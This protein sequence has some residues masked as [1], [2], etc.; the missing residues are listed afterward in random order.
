MD[1]KVYRGSWVRGGYKNRLKYGDI[2]LLNDQDRMCC[3]G[4]IL[5]QAGVDAEILFGIGYPE[6]ID[7]SVID[8]PISLGLAIGPGIDTLLGKICAQ[9][10]DDENIT[11]KIREA[12]I[13]YEF[14]QAGHTVKFVP[15]KAPWFNEI[16]VSS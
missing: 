4:Q 16:P 10:N 8:V 1:F 7:E 15:G 2:C 13:K 9:T 6:D 11:D 5:C 3:L 12:K 14:K